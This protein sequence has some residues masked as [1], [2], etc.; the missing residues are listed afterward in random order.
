MRTGKILCDRQKRN[1]CR[2]FYSRQADLQ[3]PAYENGLGSTVEPGQ[4]AGAPVRW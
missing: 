1:L 3:I 2:L 4:T